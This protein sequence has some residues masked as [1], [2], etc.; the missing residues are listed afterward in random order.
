[1]TWIQTYLI[2]LITGAV[3]CAILLSLPLQKT[4]R[5]LL[6]LSCGCLMILLTVSPL[7]QVDVQAL[8]ARLSGLIEPLPQAEVSS[9]NE[10]LQTL[11]CTQ[12]EELIEKKAEELGITVQAEVTVQYDDTVKSYLPYRVKLT[13]TG[14]RGSM[15]SLRD[16]LT[17]E[18]AIP[19][20]RQT[21]KLK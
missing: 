14:S 17:C 18:L 15:E 20:E 4:N 1:M 13:V 8:T 5:K 6:S 7:L 19:E 21:W 3:L 16:Y 11:I 10:L 9:N 12:T 2:R